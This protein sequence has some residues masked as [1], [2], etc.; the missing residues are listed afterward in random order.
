MNRGD[1]GLDEPLRAAGRQLWSGGLLQPVRSEQHARRLVAERLRRPVPQ[2]G[3]GEHGGD[4]V[5]VVALG[6]QPGGARERL[7]LGIRA[8]LGQQPRT[9]PV[10]EPAHECGVHTADGGRRA[11]SP[12]VGRRRVEVIPVW[13]SRRYHIDCQVSRP[14]EPGSR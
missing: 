6:P 8:Q 13:E 12:P 14:P 4:E 9:I 11:A 10:A 1:P 2:P 7:R 3:L 5:S